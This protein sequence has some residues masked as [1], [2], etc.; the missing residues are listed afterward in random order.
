MS[1]R[2]VDDVSLAKFDDVASLK[3][4]SATRR[5]RTGKRGGGALG[6]MMPGGQRGGR[7]SS[8]R[9]SRSLSRT[10]GSEE[11]DEV[12][13]GRGFVV[14]ISGYSPYK[15]VGE[16]MDPA[17]VEDERDGWGVITRLLHLDDIVDGNSPFKLYNK[18][19]IE[20]FKLE[21][22]EVDLDTE[23]PRGIGIEDVRFGRAKV[24]KGKQR[25]DSERVLVDPM[26]KEIISKVAKL[27]EYGAE[28]IDRSGNIVYEVQ[29]QDLDWN[30][31]N[32]HTHVFRNGG[33]FCWSKQ[34][35]ERFAVPVNY[36]HYRSF[37]QP[38]EPKKPEET[39]KKKVRIRYL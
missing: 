30:Y 31:H 35:G 5:S 13:K 12:E 6:A 39:K 18:T 25:R 24:Q 10:A 3:S 4:K 15:N 27:D 34:N 23:M 33:C 9:S 19:S 32:N 8:R 2:F 20:H 26:T 37:L 29:E 11:Q 1:V 28:V 36:T 16:L 14:T 22:G 21:I 38:E 17:G 7:T